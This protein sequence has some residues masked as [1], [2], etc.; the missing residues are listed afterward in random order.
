[1]Y[2]F[3]LNYPIAPGSSVCPARVLPSRH[4]VL[5]LVTS[6][7]IITRTTLALM[8]LIIFAN[9]FIN[10]VIWFCDL[11]ILFVLKSNICL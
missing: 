5:L 11:V 2:I 7:A 8:M 3:I 10:P 9:G 4:R 1:M 6:C